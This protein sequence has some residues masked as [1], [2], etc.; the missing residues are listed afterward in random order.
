MIDIMK[1]GL[2]LRT[3]QQESCPTGLEIFKN[4][5]FVATGRF[6]PSRF[7]STFAIIVEE[8]LGSAAVDNAPPCISH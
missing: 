8:V 7:P 6:L 3:P 1:Q 4:W 2:G 5:K